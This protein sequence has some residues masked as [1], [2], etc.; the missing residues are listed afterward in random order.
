ML[1]FLNWDFRSF[2]ID[3][4]SFFIS[5]LAYFKP[6]LI[7]SDG[8]LISCTTMFMNFSWASLYPFMSS[9]LSFKFWI[10]YKFSLLSCLIRSGS[11]SFW[12]WFDL[13]E[14]KISRSIFSS[15]EIYYTLILFY[16][17]VWMTFYCLSS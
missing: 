15:I 16:V 9:S 2:I 17:Y 4:I 11:C 14:F 5:S 7:A 8:F 10:F 1:F 3:S 12:I 13:S 6:L